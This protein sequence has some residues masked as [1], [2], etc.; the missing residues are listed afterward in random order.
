MVKPNDEAIQSDDLL[1]AITPDGECIGIKVKY[2][3]PDSFDTDLGRQQWL[4]EA[5]AKAVDLKY[6]IESGACPVDSVKDRLD[7]KPNLSS[8]LIEKLAAESRSG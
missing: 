5:A 6:E 8:D 2:G 4:K 3:M 7:M 1:L